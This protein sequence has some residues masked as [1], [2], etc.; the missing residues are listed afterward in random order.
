VSTSVARPAWRRQD[1]TP[2]TLREG[3]PG[4]VVTPRRAI[5]GR[6]LVGAW[7]IADRHPA[8]H[9]DRHPARHADRHADRRQPGAR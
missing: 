2:I 3:D 6:T 8:R 7:P 5:I 4:R 1:V 9:A